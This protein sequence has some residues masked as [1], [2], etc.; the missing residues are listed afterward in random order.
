MECDAGQHQECNRFVANSQLE[1]MQS[2]RAGIEHALDTTQQMHD[3]MKAGELDSVA[4]LDAERSLL[5]QEIFESDIAA[6]D[7]EYVKETVQQIMA[8][9]NAML[10]LEDDMRIRM[11]EELKKELGSELTASNA[12]RSYV[13][14]SQ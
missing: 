5:L 4:R 13:E 8:L 1:F 6:S 2:I 3:L 12:I 10:G 14:N 7:T 9:N 11:E